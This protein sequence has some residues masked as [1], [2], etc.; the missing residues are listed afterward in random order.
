MLSQRSLD[1]LKDLSKN[2]NRDWFLANKARYE[3]DLKKPFEE[4]IGK[5][6]QAVQQLD[7]RVQIE[8]KKAIFRINRDTRFSKDKSPYKTNV[9]AIISPAGAKGKEFP[10]FYI[11]VEQGLL[12]LGGGAYFLEKEPLHQVRQ[13]ISLHPKRFQEIIKHPDFVS[14]FGAIKG[15]QNKKLP[16]EFQEAAVNQPLLYNKQF[17]FMAELAP[18]HALG[19]EAIPFAMAYFS[20]G[21]PLND[22]LIEAL[23]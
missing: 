23:A 15:E 7:N 19:T 2:N 1:F 8:P 13:Y 3:A 16:T 12:M 5:L 11:H 6:I 21:K 22:F 18:H 4:F 9:G 10:G 17:Y 20:A 14:K